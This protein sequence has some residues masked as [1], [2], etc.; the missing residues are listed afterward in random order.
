MVAAES[1]L[2]EDEF[3]R[4]TAPLRGELIAHCYRILGSVE[5]AEDVVQ[6]VY[7][8][9]WRA[10]DR[11]EGRSSLRTW[12]YRIATR[13]AVKELR[14]SRRRPL[15]SDLTEAG[16]WP[17]RPNPEISWLEPIPDTM[18]AGPAGDPAATVVARDTMRLAFVAALQQLPARQR[19][20]L[21]LCEV[22]DWRAA[23]VAELLGISVAAVNSALQRARAR[24]PLIDKPVE[25]EQARQLELLD[26]YVA[27][28]EAADVD[29]LTA[30]LTDDARWEMPPIP[31]WF[32]GRSTI[33]AFLAERVAELGHASVIRTA[34]NGQAAVALYYRDSA[35]IGHAHALHVLTM[36]SAGVSRVVAFH[37]PTLSRFGLPAT[38]E[39][40]A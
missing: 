19:A 14:R 20:V 15:P 11:F 25:L 2:D 26:R 5:D 10:Y 18:F 32:A 9:A 4:S 8:D 33:V 1:T 13:A 3:Q 21:L 23:E 31:V 38:L 27:A 28:F 36:T 16:M 30:V 29:A 35:G 7:L 6:T 34:A 40:P 22:L 24:L 17:V 39:P 37:N 12:M